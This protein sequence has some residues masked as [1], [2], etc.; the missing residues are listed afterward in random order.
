MNFVP[1]ISICKCS[2]CGEVSSCAR[3]SLDLQVCRGCNSTN[4]LA[5]A[6]NEKDQWISGSIAVTD[7]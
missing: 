3:D 2:I 1:L 7:A 4:W 5:A 6:D